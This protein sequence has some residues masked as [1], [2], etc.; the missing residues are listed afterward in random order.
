MTRFPAR[1]A[2]VGKFRE[3][4]KRI[5]ELED[6]AMG[7]EGVA[8]AFAMRKARSRTRAR[9]KSIDQYA[10]DLLFMIENPEE[11]QYYKFASP[12]S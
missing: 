1:P 11:M 5:G 2:P 8:K 4:L 12:L 6:L 9:K 7:Y 10:D 3:L